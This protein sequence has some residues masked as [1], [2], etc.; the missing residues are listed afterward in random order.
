[1]PENLH[2]E[3]SPSMASLVGGILDD[4]QQLIRQEITLAR[5]EMQQ[6]L[7]KAK[8]A[9]VSFGAAAA[10]LALGAILLCFMLVYLVHEVAGLPLWGSFASLGAGFVV[11]GSILLAVAKNK[12]GEISLVPRQTVETMKENV[13][14]LK[15]QT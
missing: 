13:Q 11:V 2:L 8:T 1:M 6:E 10:V 7:D 9:A 15:N 12:A 14:W 3:A 4:A 5:R